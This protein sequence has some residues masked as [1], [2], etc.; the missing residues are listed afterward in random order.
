M[1]SEDEQFPPQTWTIV[2]K[3]VV[4]RLAE[5]GMEFQLCKGEVILDISIRQLPN[6]YLF[7][8][9]SSNEENGFVVRFESEASV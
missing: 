8:R 7:T 4:S 3:H 2:C 1:W 6:Y 5:S 9:N